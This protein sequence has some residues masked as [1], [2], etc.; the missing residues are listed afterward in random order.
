M[1][2]MKLCSYGGCGRRVTREEGRCPEH[3]RAERQRRDEKTRR[4]GYRSPHWQRVRRERL[5]LAGYRCELRLNC[6][7]AEATHV[8][9]DPAYRGEHRTALLEDT[10]ACCASCSGAIDAP[11]AQR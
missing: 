1:A 10:R 9:L 7:G 2:I 4:Y 3:A 5:E 11:R 8:H 6:E